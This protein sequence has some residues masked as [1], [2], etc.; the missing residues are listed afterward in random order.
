MRCVALTV[1]HEADRLY[2]DELLRTLSN[3]RVVHVHVLP[4][5]YMQVLYSSP[6][7]GRP[8]YV[9]FREIEYR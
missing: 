6:S 3:V 5:H 1:L 2:I 9:P 7:V 8:P 4:A